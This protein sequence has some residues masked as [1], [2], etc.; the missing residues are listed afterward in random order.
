MLQLDWPVVLTIRF[1]NSVNRK[2]V[3]KLIPVKE[4]WTNVVFSGSASLKGY[5]FLELLVSLSDYVVDF[6]IWLHYHMATIQ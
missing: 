2:F 4:M 3:Y 6:P 1:V 5:L